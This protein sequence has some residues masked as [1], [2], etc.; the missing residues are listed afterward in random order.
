MPALCG[1]G[2]QSDD[3]ILHALE[4]VGIEA[5]QQGFLLGLRLPH[6]AIGLG[7]DAFDLL[8]FVQHRFAGCSDFV[9]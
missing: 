1:N 5:G 4:A 8:V 9:Q 6:R 3:V 2:L 7:A